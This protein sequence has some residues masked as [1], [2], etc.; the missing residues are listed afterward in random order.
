MNKPNTV[1]RFNRRHFLIG[2]GAVAG[3]AMLE[4]CRARDLVA[5]VKR[6]TPIPTYV[7]TSISPVFTST[8]KVD[9]TPVASGTPSPEGT[10]T[11]APT[12]TARPTKKPTPKRTKTPTATSEPTQTP[13]PSATPTPTPTPY[14]PGPPSKLGIFT[15]RADSQINT[16]IQF[17]KPALVKTL[18]LDPNLGR[19]AKANSPTTI[20]VGRVPLDQV[21]LTADP[22]PLARNVAGRVLE[23]ALEPVRFESYDAW[24]AYNEPVADTPDKMKRLADLEAER[25]RLL[26]EQG[27]RAVVGNFAAGHPP[28][29]LWQYF[30]PALAAAR[31]YGGYLGVHEYSAPVM[32]W[33]FGALQSTPGSDEGDEGWLTLRYRKS[34]RHFLGPMGYGNLPLLITECGVDGTIQ[35]RPGPS[36]AMGWQDFELFW[37][38]NGLRNDMPGVYMDQL[39]WYD[40]E[41]QRDAY[42]KGAAIFAAGASPGWESYEILGRTAELLTQ[43]L[44]V[45]PPQRK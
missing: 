34:Y 21:D 6:G 24:E 45:H 17:G 39:I 12:A 4:A 3:M 30:E 33:A 1:R 31:Q 19:F 41:L 42:V 18:D 27:V 16:L 32:Q 15:T 5:W 38:S 29:E 26:G 7:S 37:N 14:P 13:T 25:T 44:S 22:M 28:L 40:S 9:T 20:V 2:L 36:E 10:T 35:P 43:Y 11:A 8:P 23:F